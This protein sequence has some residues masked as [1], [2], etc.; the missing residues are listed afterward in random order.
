MLSGVCPLSFLLLKCGLQKP[1][2]SGHNFHFIC[3]TSWVQ[4]SAWIPTILT[5]VFVIFLNQ[6]RLR[7]QLKICHNHFS[8][9][10]FQNIHKLL[11]HRVY[12]FS[13]VDTVSLNKWHT[14]C[15]HLQIIIHKHNIHTN[16]NHT[17]NLM[18]Y[19]YYFLS[20]I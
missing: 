12:I 14:E 4:K 6:F 19:F 2:S 11:Y 3:G 20:I 18:L 5:E 1:L 7:Q 16:T 15:G 10:P 9:C 8:L 17:S 13:V